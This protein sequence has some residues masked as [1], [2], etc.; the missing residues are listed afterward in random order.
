M[1]GLD[2]AIQ[3]KYHFAVRTRGDWMAAS[4]AAMT[5]KKVSRPL[6]LAVFIPIW[7]LWCARCGREELSSKKEKKRERGKGVPGTRENNYQW[8]V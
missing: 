4:R 5:N 6:D 3:R 2:P 8:E 7:N 1:A